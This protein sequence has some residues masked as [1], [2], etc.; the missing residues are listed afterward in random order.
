MSSLVLNARCDI[1]NGASDSVIFLGLGGIYFWTSLTKL[2]PPMG[3]NVVNIDSSHDV[4]H[5]S[6]TLARK[7]AGTR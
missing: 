7:D 4:L 5:L 3:P 6:S 2:G 1:L